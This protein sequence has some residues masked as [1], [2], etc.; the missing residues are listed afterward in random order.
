[1]LLELLVFIGLR[2]F[3]Q[4]N[5]PSNHIPI[6][7]YAHDR[8]AMAEILIG[9]SGFHYK[10]WAG[11]FYP[12]GIPSAE[13]LEYYAARFNTLE[14]N[15]TYYRMPDAR[16]SRQ[17]LEKSGGRLDFAIKA[18]RQLTHEISGKSITEVLPFFVKGISPFVEAKRL[19]AILLQFPQ[20]FHYTPENRVYLKSLIDALSHLP[21][22][23]EF[24]QKEWLKDSVY[25]TLEGLGA[26]FVCV[27]EP[28]LPSLVPPIVINTS[29]VGYIRFHGR[30]KKDWYG[31]DSTKRYD[32]LYD[33]A[34]L[35]EWVT[36]IIAMPEKIKKLFIFF[37]NHANAQAP[38]NARMLINLLS[39]EP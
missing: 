9:T 37:N 6:T 3:F 27:D 39:K 13:Y 20:S 33:E 29:D 16:Q 22:A 4:P 25:K 11:V 14:L 2:V 18:F 24:R 28:P 21:V 35:R 5:N 34:E 23:V 30:N 26:A 38:A 10:D 15:F 7:L 17:M 32:Y 8:D 19:G 31:T 1:M 12:E 36:K